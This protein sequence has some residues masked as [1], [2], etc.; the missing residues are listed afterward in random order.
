VLTFTSSSTVNNFC[1]LFDSRDE[2]TKL[3]AGVMVACIGPITAD[4]ARAH[5]LAVSVVPSANTIPALVSALVDYVKER[6][7]TVSR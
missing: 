4:T 2:L 3:T 6:P 7:V 5:G 1:E